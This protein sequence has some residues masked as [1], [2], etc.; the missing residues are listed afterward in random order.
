MTR[1]TVFLAIILAMVACG[2]SKPN[3]DNPGKTDPTEDPSTPDNPISVQLKGSWKISNTQTEGLPDNLVFQDSSKG[4]V[5]DDSDLSLWFDLPFVDP[6]L[7]SYSIKNNNALTIKLMT[8]TNINAY[9]DTNYQGDPIINLTDGNI[10]YEKTS[11]TEPPFADKKDEPFI[12]ILKIVNCTDNAITVQCQVVNPRILNVLDAKVGAC[13]VITGK[14][15]N[16]T[17]PIIGVLDVTKVGTA[18][19]ECVIEGV[20]PSTS[21]EVYAYATDWQGNISYGTTPVSCTTKA[22]PSR[23]DAPVTQKGNAVDLGLPSG[24]LWADR[25]IG[26]A[27]MAS[28][29]AYFAWGQTKESSN[30]SAFFSEYP[31]N[32]LLE[33]GIIE[34]KD[35]MSYTLTAQYDV[36]AQLWGNGWRLPTINEINELIKNC[37]W[38]ILEDKTEGLYGVMGT[39]KKNGE[40]IFLPMAGY[41]DANGLHDKNTAGYY[42]SS[43]SYEDYSSW[44]SRYGFRY[45]G[46]SSSTGVY[47]NSYIKRNVAFSVRPVYKK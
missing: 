18:P 5:Y 14:N 32:E 3:P 26:S 25:N 17:V 20:E 41:Y 33:E 11:D 37:N 1:K 31:D 28:N 23:G 7:F 8:G 39:S 9:F 42:L 35:H 2:C 30:C 22:F 10:Y 43:E 47:W 21:Y 4:F 16:N 45:L 27:A 34:T 40:W 44:P 24:L 6:T 38:S 29:G 15:L 46:F 12:K 13:A 36:A 19:F